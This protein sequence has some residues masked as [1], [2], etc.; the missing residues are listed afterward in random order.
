MNPR[1]LLLDTARLF[2]KNGILDPETDAALLLSSL[3]GLAPLSLRLNSDMA[4]DDAV[5]TKYQ[6]LVAR[7][8]QRVPVQ[9]IL[10]E[11]Y[12]CGRRFQVDARVLIP[13]PETELLCEWAL[14]LL[15]NASS[16]RILDLCCGS[17]C[18]GLTLKAERPDAAVTLSD[19][20]SDA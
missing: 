15:R 11:T 14:D 4:L 1:S 9:Y 5:L 17:G 18:I 12:F 7:R 13:R 2:R 19:I 6:A 8:L 16:P 3:T 20:S 10:G